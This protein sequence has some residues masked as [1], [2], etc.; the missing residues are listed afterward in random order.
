MTMY[1]S[2]VASHID[3]RSMSCLVSSTVNHVAGSFTS[4]IYF[5]SI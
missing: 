2:S 4:S 5:K 3:L 1:I